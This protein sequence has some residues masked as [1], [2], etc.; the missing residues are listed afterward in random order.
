MNG[1]Y[2]V[3]S[4]SLVLIRVLMYAYFIMDAKTQVKAAAAIAGISVAELARR[5]D[6][7][8]QAFNDRLT[9][10]G[11]FTRTEW[12]QMADAMGAKFEVH[13]VFDDGTRI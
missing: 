4:D 3:I 10:G 11:R 5:L 6:T 7:T 12:C 13:F 9:R 1:M 8:P 2:L